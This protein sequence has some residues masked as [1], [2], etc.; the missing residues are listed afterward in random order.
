MFPVIAAESNVS[1]T[2]AVILIYSLTY[3][4]IGL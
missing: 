2:R 4:D 1:R 3:L